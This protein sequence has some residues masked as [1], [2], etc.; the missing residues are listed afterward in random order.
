MDGP[1]THNEWAK[2][3]QHFVEDDDV[4]T[5]VV[6]A[7][8]LAVVLSRPSSIVPAIVSYCSSHFRSLVL[9]MKWQER[10]ALLIIECN[11]YFCPTRVTI[12]VPE[13]AKELAGWA[14][15]CF[16]ST[17]AL[18]LKEWQVALQ[19]AGSGGVWLVGSGPFK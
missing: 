4:V 13:R 8:F 11:F 3:C 5:L 16:P 6:V 7:V 18:S 14:A 15:F 9:F 10:V 2:R 1:E 12:S 19:E 17:R